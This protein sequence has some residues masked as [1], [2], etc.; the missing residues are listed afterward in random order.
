MKLT[1][2]EDRAEASIA[3]AQWLKEHLEGFL[4]SNDRAGLMVSGGSSPK[5]TF[6][7]LSHSALDWSQIDVSLTDE[8]CVPA[9][10][11]A[12]NEKMVRETLLTRSAVSGT[13]LPVGTIPSQNLSC[14]LVGM[15]E[16]GHFASIFPDHPQLEVVLDPHERPGT[17]KIKTHAS[18]HERVTVNLSALLAGEAILLLV[19]GQKKLDLV[20]APE[21]LPINALLSQN[22]TPVDVFWS[23]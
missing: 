7:V 1:L 5:Q 6:E 11:D 21:G 16:D 8:R 19:F 22:M 23:P 15:G 12:S 4:C 18:E 17:F 3:A 10:H 20:R 14:C 13:F 9:N 2:Y